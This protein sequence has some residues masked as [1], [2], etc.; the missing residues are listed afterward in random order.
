MSQHRLRYSLILC[1]LFIPVS[2]VHSQALSVFGTEFSGSGTTTRILQVFNPQ[3]ATGSV[4]VAL[5]IA[6]FSQ[7]NGN[8]LNA[9]VGTVISGSSLNAAAWDQTNSRLYFRDALGGGNLF[10]WSR[11][12]SR[13]NDVASAATIM[14]GG[15]S[16]LAD[17]ATIYN[18]GLW[19]GEDGTD[20]FYRYDLA[21]GGVRR[22]ADVSGSLNREYNFGDIAVSSAGLLYINSN[23]A[24]NQN[25]VL[26]RV[27]ISAVTASTGTP[28]GFTQIQEYSNNFDGVTQQIFFDETGT[29]LYMIQSLAATGG[30]AGAFPERSWHQINTTNGNLGTTIWTS[31]L[32]FSD[33]GNGFI[34]VPEPATWFLL[35]GTPALMGSV[36]YQ[37]NR[38][39]LE[40]KPAEPSA[41]T[42]VPQQTETEQL[43]LVS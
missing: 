32:N 28:T 30:S 14:A 4:A 40:Q 43:T 9:P 16:T 24:N 29:N 15:S 12:S 22:F 21:T 25:N 36:W 38:R 42:D 17:S 6:G 39:R 1:L 26:D 2:F 11:G 5:D 19:Y 35:L 8:I 41:T 33:L 10:Y 34:A 3:L 7:A 23:R 27:N 18:G 31:S 20:A 13:I 37:R